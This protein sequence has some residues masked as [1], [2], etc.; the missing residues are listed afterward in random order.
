MIAGN[1][2]KEQVKTR[3]VDESGKELAMTANIVRF[4]GQESPI[5]L[6]NYRRM[7]K[8]YNNIAYMGTLSE[9]NMKHLTFSAIYS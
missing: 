8:E 7:A 5:D 2:V 3:I 9:K 6:V 1:I 4:A